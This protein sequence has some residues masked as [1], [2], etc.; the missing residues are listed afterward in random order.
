VFQECY[1]RQVE[2]VR[3]WRNPRTEQ[4]QASS[5]IIRYY[6]SCTICTNCH[7]LFHR[8]RLLFSV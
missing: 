3:I 2:R 5:I 4:N 1:E 6:Y 7:V 8:N